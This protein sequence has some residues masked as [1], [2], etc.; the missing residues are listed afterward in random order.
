MEQARP[1]GDV[2]LQVGCEAIAEG[3]KVGYP[4]PFV[5]VL[6]LAQQGVAGAMQRRPDSPRG[7]VVIEH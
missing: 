5:V 4:V 1:V 7:V 2:R 3:G 6:D